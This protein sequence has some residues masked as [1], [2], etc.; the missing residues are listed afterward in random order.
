MAGIYIHYPFCRHKCAYCNFFSVASAKLNIGFNAALKEEIK[1]RSDYLG[2]EAVESLYFG[3]GTPSLMPPSDINDLIQWL[4][5]HFTI[6]EYAEIT[7]EVNPEDISINFLKELSKTKINRISVGVQSFDDNELAYLNRKH[8][9]EKSVGAIMRI[10]DAGYENISA[11]LIYGLPLSSGESLRNNLYRLID[12]KIPHISAYAL[13]V[14]EKTPL[15][16]WIKS[17]KV[18][19][20]P[21]ERIVEHFRILIDLLDE[22]DY[23]HYEISNFARKGFYS[24]HNSLYWLGGHYA[25]FGPSAHSYNGYSRQ[26][27]VKS[28]SAYINSKGNPANLTEE[29]E[30]LSHNEKYNEY[31]MTSLRTVWGCDTEHIRNVFGK[32]FERYF[33]ERI[34]EYVNNKLLVENKG[35]FALTKEGKLYADGIAS[36]LFK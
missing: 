16:N 25:G 26:W 2:I 1:F 15:A 21:E 12:M 30:F 13:T 18:L 5:K 28:V 10:Q 4:E 27:N 24:K 11:D 6:P 23:I 32:E 7:L 3:G 31:V 29:Q 17:G 33:L 19:P 35:I 14:E 22:H 36:S 20:P 34:C 9:A 8:S